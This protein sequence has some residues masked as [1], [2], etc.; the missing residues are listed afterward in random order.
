MLNQFPHTCHNA[1]GI[2]PL[3]TYLNAKVAHYWLEV[4]AMTSPM[5][6]REEETPYH[7]D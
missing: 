6:V 4:D 7:S 5:Q 1:F 2:N 3:E